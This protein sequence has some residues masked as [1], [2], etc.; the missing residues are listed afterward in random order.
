[1][2]HRLV[3]V[4]LDRAAEL[5]VLASVL[6]RQFHGHGGRAWLLLASLLGGRA[7][8]GR[9]RLDSE[10]VGRGNKRQRRERNSE[11]SACINSDHDCGIIGCG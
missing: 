5:L 4:S 10:G 8:A 9:R 1:M 6:G 3:V 7:G 11:K 2:T